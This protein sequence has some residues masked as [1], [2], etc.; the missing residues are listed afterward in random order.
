MRTSVK[1]LAN[2][3]VFALAALAATNASA[4]TSDVP[5]PQK[6][7]IV[8]LENHNFEQIVGDTANAPFLNNTIIKTGLLFTNS[9]GVEHPSQPNYLQLFSGSNQGVTNSNATPNNPYDLNLLVIKLQA[10]IAN[11]QTPAD[12]IPGLKA[13]LAQIQAALAAGYDPKIAT[14]DAFPINANFYPVF[15][16]PIQIPF[17]TP[18]LG[19]VLAN[20]G[21][22]FTEYVEGLSAT[23]AA[24]EFG[25][26]VIAKINNPA[27]PYSVGYAHRHDPAADWISA[28]PV[29]NQLPRTAVQDFANFGSDNT[30]F[31][32][33]PNVSLV[34]PNTINDMHDGAIPA[35]TAVGDQWMQKN[36]SS[37]L[38]WAKTHKSL[39]IVTTD[40]SDQSPE[41]RIMTVINGDPSLFQ[42]GSSNQSISHH[43][44][45][46]AVE[47]MFGTAYAG[48]SSVVGDLAWTGGKLTATSPA[49]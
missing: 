14:G 36:F 42:A 22:T 28:T 33:L 25:Y 10:A 11:P 15:G 12:Q 18:N 40:E 45:L 9:H 5:R 13:Q 46:R 4:Q 2:T 17:M 49:N 3:C 26:P 35:S 32:Y 16:E 21:K 6:V 24:D 48:Y 39:L 44:I 43:E 1:Q 20:A 7:V 27:D 8:V 29:G 34:V 23:G 37:Y 47:S 31:A 38:N 30:N 19:S 41:N